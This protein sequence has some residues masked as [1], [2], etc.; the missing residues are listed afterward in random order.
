MNKFMDAFESKIGPIAAKLNA[1]RYINAIKNG[2]I[3][4]MPLIIVGSFFVL[5]A[6]LPIDPY[7]DFMKNTFGENWQSYFL[8]VN[9]ATMSVMAL[10]VIVGSSSNLSKYYK[11]NSLACSCIAVASYLILTP[12]DNGAIVINSL[13]SNG[14]FLGLITSISSVEIVRFVKEHNWVIRMPDTVPENIAASFS[15]LIP[16]LIVFVIF[17]FIRIGFEMTTYKSAMNFIYQIVQYPLM[18]IGSSLPAV[19]VSI[20]AEMSLWSFGIHGT[21]VVGSV[22]DP[23]MTALSAENLA[24]FTAGGHPAHIINQQFLANFVRLGGAGATL[25]LAILLLFVSKSKQNKTLGKLAIGPI[26]FQINEPIIFG[27]PIILNPIMIIPFIVCPIVLAIVCYLAFMSGLVPII[28]GIQIPWTTPPLI[29]G[30]LL[31]GF[32]GFLLQLVCL[33]ITMGIYY[34][35][36]KMIDKKAYALENKNMEELSNE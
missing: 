13:G 27:I 16:A 1:N 24:I 2:F 12:L 11:L 17:N 26:I 32:R 9:D 23:I 31:C 25:G 34:P 3:S 6:N 29:S 7:L 22:T 30:F 18:N 10:F 20:F 19:I 8:K 14:L 4:T 5:L 21:S 36:F 28:S 35:F 33:F 15:A